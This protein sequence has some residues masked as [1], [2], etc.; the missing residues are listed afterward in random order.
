MFITFIL[1]IKIDTRCYDNS[2]EN[3]GKN[4]EGYHF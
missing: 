3:R 4:E 1:F 2:V